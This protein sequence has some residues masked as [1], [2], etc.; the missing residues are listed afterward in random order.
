MKAVRI[1]QF[2]GPEVLIHEDIPDP[3]LRQDQVLVRVKCALNHLDLWV[4]KGLPGVNLPHING[5]DIA[6]EVEEVGEYVA[7][8]RRDNGFCWR[9]WIFAITARSALPDCRISAASSPS[10]AMAWMVATAN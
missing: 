9:R 1:H 2:G 8:S 3:K 6:G 10:S 7:G 4:R 5:S